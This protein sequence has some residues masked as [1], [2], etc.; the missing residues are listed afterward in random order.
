MRK[1]VEHL[2]RMAIDLR[3]RRTLDL[4][5]SQVFDERLG[6]EERVLDVDEL[7]QGDIRAAVLGRDISERGIG[8]SIHR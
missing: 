8:D 5:I 6:R 1:L 3:D 7:G 2:R 4:G